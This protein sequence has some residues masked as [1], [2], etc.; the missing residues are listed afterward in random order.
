MSNFKKFLPMGE[1]TD[2]EEE[3]IERERHE[4]DRKLHEENREKML[5]IVKKQ[6]VKAKSDKSGEQDIKDLLDLYGYIVRS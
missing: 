4:R 5:E 3:R 6:I 1:S 2:L